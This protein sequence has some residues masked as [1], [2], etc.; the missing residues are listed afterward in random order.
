MAHAYE[1]ANFVCMRTTV[2]LDEELVRNALVASGARTK[3]EVLEL[4]LKALIEGQA[5]QRL[6]ALRGQLT[7]GQAPRRRRA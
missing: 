1:Y 4:G 5:K 2:D 7:T 6:I 3:T